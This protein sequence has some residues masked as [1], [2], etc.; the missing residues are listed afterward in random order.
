MKKIRNLF[1]ITM[2]I[3]II[4][5]FD[6][7]AENYSIDV[8]VK[9]G[10]AATDLIMKLNGDIK[11]NKNYYVL[12]VNEGDTKPILNSSDS[13]YDSTIA[14]DSNDIKKSKS[15]GLNTS[16]LNISDDWY[17]LKGY[18]Y[19]YII[20]CDE[21]SYNCKVSDSPVKVEKPE[22][23]MLSSRYH[24]YLFKDDNTVSV[25]PYF[26][27]IG[28]CGD[29]KLTVKIGLIQDNNI[30]KSLANNEANSMNKLLEYAKNNDGTSFSSLDDEF[31]NIDAS[32]FKVTNGSYYYMY[33]TINDSNG[34]Y[35]NL[36]DITVTMGE[37][38]ML[39]NDVDWSKYKP[40]GSNNSIANEKVKNPN[41]GLYISTGILLL[42]LIGGI[43][44]YIILRKK[45]KF[46]KV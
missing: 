29:H 14:P 41:T 37:N 35:R 27:Y 13:I 21:N 12:F 39:V 20:E 44:T 8:D 15:V 33:T 46:S 16:E 19:A 3:L 17:L 32:S 22:L 45:S 5:I 7:N 34:L 38:N 11:N 40:E 36:E 1:T 2:F 26:P 31:K 4:A 9:T 6:V 23:P 28:K 24:I 10:N 18:N 42:I 25:F 43:I 30:L